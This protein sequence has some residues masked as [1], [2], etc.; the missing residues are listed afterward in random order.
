VDQRQVFGDDRIDEAEI[1]GYAAQVIE[2]AAGDEDHG[3]VATPCFRD[4][5]STGGGT[6]SLRAI[7]P[8]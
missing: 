4:A 6:R 1:A 2:N 5:S 8:S 3:H 7:V